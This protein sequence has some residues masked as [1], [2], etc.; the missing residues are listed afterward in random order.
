[1]RERLK[2]L[3]N[4]RSS[5]DRRVRS[6]WYLI[7]LGF[8]LM[9]LVTPTLRLTAFGLAVACSVILC[10]VATVWGICHPRSVLGVNR[11]VWRWA[12]G[13]TIV[14][15]LAGYAGALDRAGT[16]LS[17]SLPTAG[18][19]SAIVILLPF[20]L[21]ICLLY[22]W[23]GAFVSAYVVRRWS[24][25]ERLTGVGLTIWW[26]LSVVYLLIVWASWQLNAA[27]EQVDFT[28]LDL[29]ILIVPLLTMLACRLARNPEWELRSLAERALLRL[30]RYLTFRWRWERRTYQLDFRGALLGLLVALIVFGLSRPLLKAPSAS[31]LVWM[32][33]IRNQEARGAWSGAH[34][35]E[36]TTIFGSELKK[37]DE[38]ILTLRRR[39]VLIDLDTPVLRAAFS[40]SDA[41]ASQPP[42]DD[43]DLPSVHSEAALQALIIRRLRALGAAVTVL[44]PPQEQPEPYLESTDEILTAKVTEAG[45]E[46]SRRDETLLATAMHR[47][48]NVVLATPHRGE[49][50]RAARADLTA[51]QEAAAYDGDERLSSYGSV[52]LPVL[53]SGSRNAPP[54]LPI[55][56]ARCYAEHQGD[57]EKYAF[58]SRSLAPVDFRNARPGH[59]FLHV[60]AS[61]LFLRDT[62]KPRSEG[63]FLPYGGIWQ[64]DPVFGALLSDP[65]ET[66]PENLI[67]TPRGE[68]QTLE[69]CIHGR[70]VFLDSPTPRFHETPT[71][72]LPAREVLAYGTATVLAHE[73]GLRVSTHN[74]FKIT[75]VI[76]MLMG[77]LCARRTPFEAA[78]RMVVVAAL[79]LFASL[80]C[81]M[82]WTLW[83]DAVVPLVTILL[84]YLL[85]T[86]LSFTQQSEKNRDLLK[87]FV[88]PEFVDAMLDH[89]SERLGLE[90]KLSQ[91][92]VLFADVRNFT[93]FAQQHRP[94]AVFAAVNQYMTALTNAL[95]AYGGV[96]DKYTGDGLMAWFPVETNRPEHVETAVRA[97]LAMRDAALEISKARLEEG[98]PVLQFGF[99]M[100]FGEAMI[101]LVGNEEHQI[102]YTALGHSVVVSARMQTLANGGEVIISEAVYAALGQDF[103][104]EAQ[105]PVAVKGISELVHP[106][107]VLSA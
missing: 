87:R 76:G 92:C 31:L 22:G 14:G 39:I 42:K 53:E 52:R 73:Q 8:Y 25:P 26:L 107:L 29:S 34:L 85:V 54:S 46:R 101:G 70:I 82:I 7:V 89:P 33:Q 1:M 13:A 23:L 19:L 37:R 63:L 62:K 64:P 11:S 86:Q 2:V 56:I 103:R 24:E 40:P 28:F 91:V 71:G 79:M 94:E 77:I 97:T 99:G 20:L 18:V 105:E 72:P 17:M 75:M 84:T 49:D 32:I 16:L 6:I 3:W 21:G 27:N 68:W 69:E 95:H 106:Y 98:K 35:S 88:A 15:L 4:L 12:V 44:I 10:G 90:G 80:A 9:V 30:S 96:L 67:L 59:D 45:R 61:T 36:Q 93:G 55:L 81:Y 74:A 100:H 78:G 102:N 41:R 51:L 57:P 38:G 43:F 83:V 48:A 58:H 5:A 66:P 60:P 47:A 65:V 104:V 50:P